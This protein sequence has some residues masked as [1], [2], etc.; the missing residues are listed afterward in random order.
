M[1]IPYFQVS[2]FT[3]HYLGGN[4]AG[5]CLLEGQWLPDKQ[6]QQIAWQNNLAETAFII[7]RY[8]I[9]IFAGSALPSKS[10]SADMRPSL[11]LMSFLN[12]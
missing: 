9:T 11:P 10:T 1:K 8:S 6:M 12:T 5:I 2:A 7:E 3:R 4:P